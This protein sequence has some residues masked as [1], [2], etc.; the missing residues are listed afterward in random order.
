MS[1]FDMA[2]IKETCENGVRTVSDAVETAKD[3]KNKTGA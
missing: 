3:I 1:G 2:K